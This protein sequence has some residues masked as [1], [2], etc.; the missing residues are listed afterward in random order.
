MTIE[1]TTTGKIIYPNDTSANNA[2]KGL[3]AAG[4]WIIF[5]YIISAT[6]APTENPSVR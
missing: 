3:A 1:P 6:V 4:G 5:K 2:I